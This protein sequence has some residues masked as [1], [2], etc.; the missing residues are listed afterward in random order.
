MKESV[1]ASAGDA[2]RPA[3]SI[4]PATTAVTR[5]RARAMV[6]PP[7]SP[8]TSDFFDTLAAGSRDDK[9]A[10]CQFSESVADFAFR[11]PSE[12]SWRIPRKRF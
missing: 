9:T 10:I 4:V 11:K 1:A 8:L 12:L 7:Y 5:L 3:E 6:V 2:N